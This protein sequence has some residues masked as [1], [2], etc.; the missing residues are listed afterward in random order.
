M[1]LECRV[2]MYHDKYDLE[3]A[4][5]KCTP[6]RFTEHLL[7]VVNITVF[8]RLPCCCMVIFGYGKSV[9]NVSL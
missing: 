2:K 3:L 9:F 8:S 7:T 5:M 1:I 4:Y 6:N